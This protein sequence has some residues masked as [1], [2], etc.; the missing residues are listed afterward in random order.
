M[1]QALRLIRR[2]TR[3]FWWV[4]LFPSG[5]AV[6]RSLDLADDLARRY[7]G[8]TLPG[9]CAQRIEITPALREPVLELRAQVLRARL[10][11]GALPGFHGDAPP[12]AG[13]APRVRAYL[14][15]LQ[16]DD[17]Q[18]RMVMDILIRV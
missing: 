7:R 2:L 9:G 14:A 1:M 17:Q 3:T 11:M 18:A 16:A 8:L 5:R 6:R 12:L 15:K 10:A 4:L 13:Q